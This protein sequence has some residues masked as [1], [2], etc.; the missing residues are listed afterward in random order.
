[1]LNIVNTNINHR[2]QFRVSSIYLHSFLNAHFNVTSS[3][4]ENTKVA[5]VLFIRSSALIFK[6]MHTVV[7]SG[8]LE[9]E[10]E[11]SDLKVFVSELHVSLYNNIVSVR[12]W[13][14][15]CCTSPQFD[16]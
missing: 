5:G 15:V 12:S 4:I 2:I 6:P 16:V 8:I 3:P 13:T 11:C 9:L 7:F 14:D 1:V 10:E